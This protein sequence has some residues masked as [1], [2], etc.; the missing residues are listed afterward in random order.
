MTRRKTLSE[1]ADNDDASAAAS[2]TDKRPP[3]SIV[4]LN[5]PVPV[6]ASS[7]LGSG[8]MFLCLVIEELTMLAGASLT[9]NNKKSHPPGGSPFA[10]ASSTGIECC[11]Y[12]SRCSD[13]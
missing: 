4:R 8:Q 11:I 10:L 7:P 6:F 3:A 2:Q 13:V 1:E 12:C 5:R 9:P